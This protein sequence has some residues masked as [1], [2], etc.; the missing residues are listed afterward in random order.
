M[1]W[2]AIRGYNRFGVKDPYGERER[3]EVPSLMGASP[4]FL[5]FGSVLLIALLLSA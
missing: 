3:N 4:M 2:W 1:G 5:V